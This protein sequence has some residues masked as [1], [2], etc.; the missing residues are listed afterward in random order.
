MVTLILIQ[1]AM[2]KF[3]IKFKPFMGNKFSHDK[4]TRYQGDKHDKKNKYIDK[5]LFERDS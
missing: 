1:V 5:Y 2:A 4:D 3:F